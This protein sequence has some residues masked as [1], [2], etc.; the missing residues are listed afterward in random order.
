[1]HNRILRKEGHGGT[2][3][4]SIREDRKCRFEE[5]HKKVYLQIQ[6]P[7]WSE[8]LTIVSVTNE[9][10]DKPSRQFCNMKTFRGIQIDPSPL[11]IFFWEPTA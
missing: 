10:E 1:M 8:T 2:P 7:D 5:F 11:H 3:R 9:D 4:T 6:C